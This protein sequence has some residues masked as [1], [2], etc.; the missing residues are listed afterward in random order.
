MPCYDLQNS[1]KKSLRKI[2]SVFRV[3][4]R[5]H[6]M[7]L[8]SWFSLLHYVPALLRLEHLPWQCHEIIVLTHKLV[9]CQHVKKFTT[10]FETLR[11]ITVF[12]R[13]CHS[14]LPW[15]SSIQPTFSY[16]ILSRLILIISSHLRLS[17]SSVAFSSNC[18]AESF[19]I[20]PILFVFYANVPYLLSIDNLITFDDLKVTRLLFVHFLWP[21]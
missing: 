20:S 12:T 13:S 10:L 7:E 16:P 14:I 17:L 11:F 9:L 2:Y 6:F 5:T 19:V 21:I 3:F 4:W 8:F 18:Q 1:F 15:V